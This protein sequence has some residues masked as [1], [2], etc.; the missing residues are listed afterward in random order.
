VESLDVIKREARLRGGD[1]HPFDKCLIATGARPTLPKI[2]G[3]EHKECTFALRTQ[4]DMIRL[5]QALPHM[6]QLLI[7]GP[8]LI[9]IK[10]AECFVKRGKRVTLAEEG[11]L[12]D[13]RMRTSEE[14]IYAAGDVCQV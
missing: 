14:E 3:L 5:S 4:E 9:G 10:L 11:I 8:S 1:T 13:H 6:K 12:V 7:L 2:P